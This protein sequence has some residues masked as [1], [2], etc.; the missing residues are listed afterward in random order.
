MGRQPG[1]AAV[2]SPGGRSSATRTP[3]ATNGLPPPGR[4][5]RRAALREEARAAPASGGDRPWR[6]RYVRAALIG[7]PPGRAAGACAAGAGGPCRAGTPADMAARRPEQQQRGA[8]VAEDG[9]RSLSLSGQ[10][11]WLDLWL[12]ILFD[13]VLFVV[14]YLLP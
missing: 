1:S 3:T 7:S 12:F 6:R 9:G 13:L 14:I 4:V 11:Y 10:S 2:P 8:E 5:G